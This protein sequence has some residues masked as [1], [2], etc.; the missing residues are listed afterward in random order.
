MDI[1]LRLNKHGY[2]ILRLKI[3]MGIMRLNKHGYSTQA[4][5]NMNIMRLNKCEYYT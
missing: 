1:I 2:Y 5:I 4:E 3:S